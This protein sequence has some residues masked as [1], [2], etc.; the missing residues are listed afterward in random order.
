MP[1]CADYIMHTLHHTEISVRALIELQTASS[2]FPTGPYQSG[3]ELSIVVALLM[4][5][6]RPQAE[7]HGSKNGRSGCMW[8]HPTYIDAQCDMTVAVSRSKMKT[9]HRYQLQ[10]TCA[11]L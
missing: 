4:K 9:M 8:L 1:C 6:N 7:L 10:M 2:D 11:N 3:E 5:H